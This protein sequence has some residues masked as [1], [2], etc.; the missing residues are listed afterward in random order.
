[1]QKQNLN[2]LFAFPIAALLFSCAVPPDEPS[3]E[4]PAT[5]PS[6][7]P[8]LRVI[9]AAEVVEGG[10][11]SQRQLIADLLYEALQALDDDRLLTPVDDNAHARFMRVLAYEP[12][13]EIALQ[14]LQD[15]VMRYLELA[16]QS[17]RRGLFDEAR[18]LIDRARFV[19]EDNAA[20]AGV[21][22]ALEAEMQ[23]NDLFFS[24][25]SAAFANRSELAISQLQDIAQQAREANAFFLITAPSDSLARWMYGVM[26]EAVEGYRL[27][28][29]I[30][31]ASQ[32]S[33]RLRM[34]KDSE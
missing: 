17:L 3:T 11:I 1:M 5:A 19:D 26:R 31:I 10:R 13:N 28:G 14:G 18:S 27:R 29:N 22:A 23:S 8:N 25:E 16:Q 34:P 9:G 7:G 15:I 32:V 30:E 24:L 4:L 33:I 20:I 6:T 21:V 12:N 2:A